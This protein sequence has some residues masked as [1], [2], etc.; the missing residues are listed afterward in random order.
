LINLCDAVH[1]RGKILGQT[2]FLLVLGFFAILSLVYFAAENPDNATTVE[3]MKDALRGKKIIDD[4]KH[5]SLTANRTASTLKV[6]GSS[7]SIL[8]LY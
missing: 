5:Q 7:V 8:D 3:L 4:L 1:K 2:W 6:R